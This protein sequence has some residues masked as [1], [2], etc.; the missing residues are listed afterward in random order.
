MLKPTI[1]LSKLLLKKKKL[2][3]VELYYIGKYYDIYI[4]AG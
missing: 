2:I 3:C 1:Y 4:L